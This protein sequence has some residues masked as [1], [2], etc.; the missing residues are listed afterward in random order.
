MT[1]PHTQNLDE[2]GGGFVDPAKQSARAFRQIL[3]VMARPGVVR[4]IEG[5]APP[6]P[7]GAAMG[8]VMLT[9][10]DAETPV[11]LAPTL[12]GG[13]VERWLAFHCGAPLAERGDAM[14]AFGGWA[15]LQ[16]LDDYSIGSAE[17][18]DRSATLVAELPSLAGAARVTG[19]GIEHE[20]RL[21]VPDVDAFRANA[22]LYPLGLDFILTC[23]AELAAAPRSLRIE[24]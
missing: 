22:A 12:R 8:A 11:W 7:L 16:P 3:D 10:C 14:F 18:P 24:D 20:A 13:A 9:L 6:P 19:P 1:A 4:R 2:L 21:A 23:G 15:E 5:V 17:Y